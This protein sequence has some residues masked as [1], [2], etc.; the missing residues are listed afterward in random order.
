MTL[1]N[2]DPQSLKRP[3]HYELVSAQYIVGCLEIR[4]YG[5]FASD[6]RLPKTFLSG[7]MVTT[8]SR[9]PC[10]NDMLTAYA[11]EPPIVAQQ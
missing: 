5:R 1:D 3:Y 10:L 8:K 2:S 11:H 6:P 7:V 4:N 9:L